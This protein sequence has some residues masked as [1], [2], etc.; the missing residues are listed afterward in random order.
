LHLLGRPFITWTMPSTLTS[1]SLKS[2]WNRQWLTPVILATQDAETRRMEV[3]SQSGQIV[4]ETLSWKNPLQKWAGRVAQDV[5]P[6]F[7][8]LDCKKEKKIEDK[9]TTKWTQ[10]GLWQTPKW[11]KGHYKKINKEDNTKY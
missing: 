2:L 8:P 5:V 10:R 4:C 9:E 7:K 1:I 6:E 11:N 3:R